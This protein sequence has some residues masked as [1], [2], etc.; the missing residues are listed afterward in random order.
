M[1]IGNML[2]KT[3]FDFLKELKKHNTKEWFDNHRDE[4]HEVYENFEA[5]TQDLINSISKFDPSIA[6]SPPLAKDCISRLNRD[7][8]NFVNRV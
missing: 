5:F 1:L 6:S 2:K 8:N 4:Y 7:L 3:T